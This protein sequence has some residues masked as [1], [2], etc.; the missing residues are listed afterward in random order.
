MFQSSNVQLDHVINIF[1][2]D[3]LM[4]NVCEGKEDQCTQLLHHLQICQEL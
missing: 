1:F 3:I 2:N 4:K